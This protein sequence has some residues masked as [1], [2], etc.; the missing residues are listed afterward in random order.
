MGLPYENRR[1]GLGEYSMKAND[2]KPQ[3][4]IGITIVVALLLASSLSKYGSAYAS[5]DSEAATTNLYLIDF[6]LSSLSVSQQEA[7]SAYVNAH[8][9]KMPADIHDYTVTAQYVN[10]SGRQVVGLVPTDVYASHWA[11]PLPDD[12]PVFL[13]LTGSTNGGWSAE[14]LP[15]PIVPRQSSSLDYRFPWTNGH[16]WL[17][18]QGYHFQSLGYS[19]DFSP[20]SNSVL[21]VL[22]IESGLLQPICTDPYEG[23]VKVTHADGVKS[24]YLHL[25]SSSIPSGLFNQNIPQGQVLGQAYTGSAKVDPHPY[26]IPGLANYKFATKCGCGNGTH[27]HFEASSQDISIQGSLVTSISDS[28]NGTGYT[29]TNGETQSG[30]PLTVNP[31]P[32]SPSAGTCSNGWNQ[33]VGFAGQPAYT[34]RNAQSSSQSTNWATWIPTIAQAGTYGV[35][36]YIPNHGTAFCNTSVSYDTTNAV[37]TL[38]DSNNNSFTKSV[39][40]QPL[41]DVWVPLGDLYCNPGQSCRV[42]LTDITGEQLLSRTVSFSAVRFTLKSSPPPVY[43]ISGS[44]TDGA[45]SGLGGV[46]VSAGGKTVQTDGNGN[47]V[48]SDL[49]A[50]VYT[51]S[52]SKAEYTFSPGSQAVT[53]GPN[54]TGVNF[55]ASLVTYS[56]RGRVSDSANGS[57]I[58]GAAVSA[59]GKTAQT[60]GEG[61]YTLS[62]LGSGSYSVSVS[63]AGYGFNPPTRN[64]TLGP[65]ANGVDF[66]GTAATYSIK[67]SVTTGAGALAGV[68]ISAGSQTATTDASGNYTIGGL[69]GGVYTLVPSKAGYSFTPTSRSVTVGPD[70]LGINFVGSVIP[71]EGARLFI[72]PATQTVGLTGQVCVQARVEKS[73]E[74]HAFEFTLGF[75]PDLLEATNVTL[76]PFLGSTGRTLVTLPTDIN[77]A[78]GRV[79]FGAATL[80]AAPGAT[81]NGDLATVC[82]TPK[83]AGTA[84]LDLLVGKLSGPNGAAIPVSLAGGS[85]TITSCYF[86]DFDCNNE[87]DIN[88]V[89]QV[90]GQW[91]KTAGQPGFEAKYDV[92][93][94]GEIDI[95]DIQ[96]VASAWG[97]PNSRQAPK[98]SQAATAL[99]F[100][101]DPTQL[102][103]AVG[104]TRQIALKVTGA[105]NLGAFEIKLHYDGALIRVNSVRLTDFLE[106]TGRQTFVLGPEID[107]TAGQVRFGAATIG[108]QPGVTGNGQIALI[109]VT[110]LAVGDGAL[111]LHDGRASDPAAVPITVSLID[112]SYQI[113][114][115]TTGDEYS[116]MMPVILHKP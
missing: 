39:N 69:T 24:G 85:V 101:I 90:A 89:Q 2:R 110:A 61:N 95:L 109:E 59:G 7:I 27:L 97:W 20:G 102:E 1:A 13:T 75:P 114:E 94:N 33:I 106:S 80:G 104:E 44:I 18:T 74:L 10:S 38:T 50:G 26:C 103:L 41:A 71:V 81:G 67:G 82:F 113:A 107:N 66:T 16:T 72:S 92:V 79:K 115:G 70:A 98:V 100:S 32:I 45:G 91:G 55:T 52:P 54:A 4:F 51:I 56:I 60:D 63:K 46:S 116:L 34:T 3:L 11:I 93:P 84:A 53:V 108:W 22:A 14:F 21:N 5:S 57:G 23:M 28:K 78:T 86:A 87:V 29:S 64:V 96:K 35:E 111:D 40:Q 42:R 37:Y 30:D 65:D 83:K 77:N 99:S 31:P 58:S 48:I 76:G 43:S 17:K 15:K 112:G 49:S 36:A 73:P 47:Y 25:S 12:T 62:G 88:D 68:T 6:G 105:Q 19:I 8:A 9:D